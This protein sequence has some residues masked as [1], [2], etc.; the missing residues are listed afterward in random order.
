MTSSLVWSASTAV[1]VTEIDDEH[2]EIFDAISQVREA[3]ESRGSMPAIHKLAERLMG[4]LAEHFAHEERLMRAARYGSTHWHQRSHRAARRR[5]EQFVGR[6][7][8]GDTAA[9]H[10]LVEYMTCWLTDH[11]SVADRMMGSALRNHRRSMA[12]MTFRAGTRG[13]DECT[14]VDTR[15]DILRPGK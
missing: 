3:L 6:L 4:C 11:A 10:E 12:K 9:G 15:G 7:K 2:R 5:V 8:E 14:W 13:A 1:F